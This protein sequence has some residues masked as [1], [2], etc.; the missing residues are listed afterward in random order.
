LPDVS[1]LFPKLLGNS[2]FQY[3]NWAGTVA[4]PRLGKS[5]VVVLQRLGQVGR[6]CR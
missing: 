3:G 6:I 4:I 1:K 5:L 2:A